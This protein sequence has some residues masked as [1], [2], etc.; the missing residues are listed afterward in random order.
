MEEKTLIITVKENIVITVDSTDVLTGA[1]FNKVLRCV[2]RWH[3]EARRNCLMK[4][5]ELAQRKEQED[6]REITGSSSVGE[7]VTGNGNEVDAGVK[8]EEPDIA[9]PRDEKDTGV[10]TTGKESDSVDRGLTTTGDKEDDAGDVSG[11]AEGN[12]E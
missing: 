7:E 3:K 10:E 11:E 2:R 4:A 5:H 9:G 6:A 1:E 8:P 12:N